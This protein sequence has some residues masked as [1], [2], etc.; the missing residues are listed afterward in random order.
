MG[1]VPLAQYDRA[2]KM[3]LY[4]V[5]NLTHVISPV[6]HPILSDHQ[7]D[8]R[9]VYQKYLKVVKFLSLL[10][11]FLTV[12]CFWCS[13]EIILI[14]FGDQW[15]DAAR[16]FKWLSLSIWAQMV[17]SSIGA[18]FQSL[19]NT[20]LMFNAGL[21]AAITIV[22]CIVSGIIIGNGD[23]SI[24]SMFISAAFYFSFLINYIILVKRAFGYSFLKFL[25]ALLN[26]IL[27]IGAS[28]FVVFFIDK[29]IA[30]ESLF[31]SLVCKL[32]LTGVF[33][34]VYLV[35]FYRK[36]LYDKLLY[37]FRVFLE[38]MFSFV[39]QFYYDKI[40]KNGYGVN[41]H[42]RDF[43]IV[44][45][46]TSF[47]PRFNMLHYCLKSLLNQTLKPDKIILFLTNEEIDN[48]ENLPE[49]VK[50]LVRYGITIETVQENIKPH[51]KYY[52]AMQKFPESIVITVDDD[53]FYNRKFVE[54]M[55]ESYVK[56]PNSISARR[57]H[58]MAIKDKNELSSY[59][60]WKFEYKKIKKPSLELI[61][62]GSAGSL[63]PPGIMPK[64]TFNIELI[65]NLC[66]DADDIW[67]KFMEIRNGI[68]VVLVKNHWFN[69][70]GIN[71]TQTVALGKTNVRKN[72]ND[73]YIHNLIQYFNINF[74]NIAGRP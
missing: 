25:F 45:S 68:P 34:F 62:A 14:I 19:G 57:V 73:V 54:A 20:M 38:S 49:P 52:Y 66:L 4:P 48:V 42:K 21:F 7:N 15:G 39:Y 5:Q 58:K 40:K 17:T 3:M 27:F 56:H 32:L 12:A 47:P 65:R 36:M 72:Q 10:G 64:E 74:S 11:V 55:Y 60:E 13:N 6:L 71:N 51:N 8:H 23:L 69:T 9:Y 1:N 59:N 53:C 35:L 67:L 16:S 63:Y 50:E 22:L 29:Y 30:I 18:V 2:Y 61:A 31:A 28:L 33:Y 41:T 46:L 44:I 26:D 70:I 43:H 24:V 37:P